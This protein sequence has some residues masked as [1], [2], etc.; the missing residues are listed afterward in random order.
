MRR[1]PIQI[2]LSLSLLTVVISATGCGGGSKSANTTTTTTAA[3]TTAAGTTTAPANTSA[4]LTTTTATSGGLGSIESAANC[5]SISDLAPAF[6]QALQGAGG[7]IQKELAVFQQFAAKTPA[8]IRPDFETLAHAISKAA[9]ALKGVNLSNGKTPSAATLAK[10]ASL[11][12]EFNGPALKKAE[13]NIQAWANK[14]C[15]S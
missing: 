9:D 13:A 5:K 6:E 1:R 12:S 14:N 3:T 2:F 4:G 7:N 8:D 15:H 11:S 10:L